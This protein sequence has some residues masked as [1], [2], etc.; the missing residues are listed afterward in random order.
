VREFTYKDSF[1]LG[2]YSA[3][4]IVLTPSIEVC[5]L[6]NFDKN[7]AGITDLTGLGVVNFEVFPH[8]SQVDEG[9]M[10]DYSKTTKLQVQTIT[11]DSYIVKLIDQE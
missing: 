10:R 8:Y 9:A 2:G 7:L 6:P 3:G 5:R 1:V 4:A 11:N